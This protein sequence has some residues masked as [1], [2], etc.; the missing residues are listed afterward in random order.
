M[1][2]PLK[3]ITSFTQVEVAGQCSISSTILSP[4]FYM[5][6]T[7]ATLVLAWTMIS[8]VLYIESKRNLVLVLISCLS[9]FHNVQPFVKF[10]RV[11]LMSLKKCRKYFL[12]TLNA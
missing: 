11:I 5:L 1:N 10:N 4:H 8:L 3:P 7:L 12:K 9:Q 6:K 2:W